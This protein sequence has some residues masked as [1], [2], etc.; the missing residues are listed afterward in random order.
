[1]SSSPV[2]VWFR[3]DLRLT[4]NPAVQ[5]AVLT[6]HPVIF[7]YIWSPEEE[8]AW[9]PGSASRWWLHHSLNSLDESLRALG[10]CLVVRRGSTIKALT[11]LVRE[12]GAQQVLWNARYEPARLSI[13]R[14][15]IEVLTA[16]DVDVQVF[17]GS[18]LFDPA[19]TYN[20][21]RKPYLVFTPY[22]NRCRERLGQMRP[23][24][25]APL[26]LVSPF[27]CPSP[28]SVAHLE[29]LPHI[30]WDAGLHATWQPGEQGAQARLKDFVAKKLGAYPTGRNLPAN[31]EVSMI[32]PHLHF[33]EISPLQVC[34]AIRDRPEADDQ[35][36]AAV[37]I[38]EIAWREFAHYL[39]FHFPHTTERSLRS[40]FDRFE[41]HQSARLLD[42]WQKGRTGYPIVDAGMRELWHT[43]WMHNRVRMIVASFLVKDLLQPWQDGARWFWD[44]LVDADLSNNTL[45]WQW[46]AGCGADAAPFFRIFN[47][48]LQ[49]EKF[50][51]KGE[52]VRRWLP[53]LKDLP[54]KWIQRP[55]EA[56]G[57]VL[58]QAGVTLGSNYP[59]PIVDHRQARQRALAAY[60]DI[61]LSSR[62]RV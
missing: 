36:A 17:N 46:T 37:Y 1:M 32:S 34:Y 38:R 4:D 39:L 27:S 5:A 43:G 9:P 54:P 56:P 33:G 26:K 19:Q 21:E 20:K 29:L 3:Q 59:F 48:V 23:A 2:L 60:S 10:S 11:Q 18:L 61:R 35:E 50:D 55:W 57:A 15:C 53:E 28:I 49:G 14:S 8:G 6:G 52:Y 62:I 41:W 22:W 42:A 12:T 40:E 45:G 47:P 25:A 31:A 44:T 24:L 51:Q 13:D 16:L 30:A 7:L 58:A